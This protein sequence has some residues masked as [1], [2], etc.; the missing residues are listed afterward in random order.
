MPKIDVYYN[1]RIIEDEK[2][3]K[4][5]IDD[6]KS[7]FSYDFILHETDKIDFEIKFNDKTVYSLD[8]NFDSFK[9][10]DKK[11]LSKSKKMLQSAIISVKSKIYPSSDDM[12]IDDY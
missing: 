1:K 3:F 4:S 11:V 8:D 5:S 6:L 9:S 7:K 2:Y 10:I 12:S